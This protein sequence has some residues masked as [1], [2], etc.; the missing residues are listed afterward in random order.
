M[1]QREIV[2]QYPDDESLNI[3]EK[4]IEFKTSLSQDKYWAVVIKN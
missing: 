4:S 2:W 3:D 1:I